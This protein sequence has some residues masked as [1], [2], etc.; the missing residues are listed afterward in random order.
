[1]HERNNMISRISFKTEGLGSGSGGGGG[2]QG[3]E[4]TERRWA[5]HLDDE[6]NTNVKTVLLKKT[7]FSLRVVSE[8]KKAIIKS[9][10]LFNQQ[11]R[12]RSRETFNSS[13]GAW[14]PS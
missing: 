5:L 11:V 8:K 1:M 14:G 3:S 10:F 12:M 13:E 9:D 6:I 2:L 7:L 4:E